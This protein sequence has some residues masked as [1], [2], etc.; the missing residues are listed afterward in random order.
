MKHKGLT[1]LYCALA[2]SVLAACNTLGT[3][4]PKPAAKQAVEPASAD[5]QLACSSEVATR[6]PDSGNV[7]PLSSNLLGADVFRIRLTSQGGSYVCDV[8]RVG[9]IVSLLPAAQS[10][11]QLAID[12]DAIA[13]AN[14]EQQKAKK[15][16]LF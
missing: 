6:F 16:K 14:K 10:A 7:L 15:V 9:I 1:V 8:N 2:A 4:E 13:N 5:L 3:S 11:D 12:E